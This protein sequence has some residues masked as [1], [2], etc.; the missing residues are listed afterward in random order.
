MLHG[1]LSESSDA[2]QERLRSRD[3]FLPAA[4]NLLNNLVGLGIHTFDELQMEYG[5][6]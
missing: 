6:L 1:L 2:C 5:V 3:L 4:Q